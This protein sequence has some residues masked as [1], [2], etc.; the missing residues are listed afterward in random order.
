[1]NSNELRSLQAPLKQKYKDHPESAILTLQA[2]GIIGKGITCR[3]E[4]GKAL[5]EAGL[6]PATGGDGIAACSG[7][8]LLEALAQLV[9]VL[10]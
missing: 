6:H 1:M 7:G 4:T 8:M 9:P 2:K 5:V 3:V 10:L